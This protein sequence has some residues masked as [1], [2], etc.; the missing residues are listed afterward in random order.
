M[1]RLIVV[2]CVCGYVP[3]MR[4]QLNVTKDILLLASYECHKLTV[5]CQRFLLCPL[6]ECTESMVVTFSLVSGIERIG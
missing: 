2:V 6:F 5:A 3:C 4:W 1:Y